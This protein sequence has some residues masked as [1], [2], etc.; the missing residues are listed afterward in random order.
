MSKADQQTNVM[1]EQMDSLKADIYADIHKDMRD[2]AEKLRDGQGG[3]RDTVAQKLRQGV[4]PEHSEL[5][6]VIE[7]LSLQAGPKNSVEYLDEEELL[8][9]KFSKMI[10]VLDETKQEWVDAAKQYL[11]DGSDDV[12]DF[13]GI[14]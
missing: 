2:V 5:G 6:R 3:F 7:A 13:P 10:F 12:Q 8:I 1:E 14:S 4:M 9:G 11:A